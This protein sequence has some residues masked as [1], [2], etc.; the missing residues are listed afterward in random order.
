MSVSS[1]NDLR[2]WARGVPLANMECRHGQLPGG[3]C[4]C[5]PEVEAKV[6]AP[7]RCPVCKLVKPVTEIKLGV[8]YF[9]CGHGRALESQPAT[10]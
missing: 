10:A 4:G 5:W 9:G 2:M 7:F 8:T 3:D 6:G 1:D